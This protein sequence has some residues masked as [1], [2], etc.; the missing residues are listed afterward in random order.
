[1]TTTRP[2][3]LHLLCLGLLGLATFAGAASLE[4]LPPSRG[5]LAATTLAA[6]RD[7]GPVEPP[8]DQAVAFAWPLAADT[9]HAAR[10]EPPTAT[11]RGYWLQT[12]AATLGRGVALDTTAEGAVVRVNP[13]DRGVAVL[14]PATFVIVSGSGR[15]LEGAAAM[16]QLVSAEQL[17]ASDNPFP[18]GTAAFRLRPELGSGRFLLRIPGLETSGSSRFVV[19]VFEPKSQVVATLALGAAALLEGDRVEARGAVTVAGRPLPAT[20]AEAF[21]LSPEGRRTPVEL[22]RD[23]RGLVLSSPVGRV[24]AGAGLWELELRLEA[25]SENGLVRRD[26]RAAFAVATPT[27]RLDGRVE[28]VEADGLV[29]RLGVETAASGRYEI[30]GALWGKAA[31]GALVPVAVAHGAAPLGAGRGELELV[32]ADELIAASGAA[33]PFEVRDLQLQ[34]Q[35][36]MGMLHRQ[37]R[38]L[39]IR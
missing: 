31:D 22:N 8:T 7:A 10:P 16:D 35:G 13:L 11:S 32:V 18:E 34:D 29:V 20:A 17:A 12:T 3:R 15:E 38:A 23:R 2:L 24:T 27:A 37:A 39:V 21:L 36:R 25:A 9:P 6:P 4:L 33:A 28:L 26:V 1:M 14:D 5:D 19:H 30:R